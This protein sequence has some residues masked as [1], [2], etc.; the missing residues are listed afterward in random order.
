[1][2]ISVQNSKL[3]HTGSELSQFMLCIS[4]YYIDRNVIYSYSTTILTFTSVEINENFAKES[5]EMLL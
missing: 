3:T 1:M 2:K 5:R 4:S